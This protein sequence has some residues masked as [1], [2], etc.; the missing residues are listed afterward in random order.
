[1][2][3]IYYCDETFSARI[4]CYR[5]IRLAEKC[6]QIVDAKNLGPIP[7]SNH[8]AD[9]FGTEKVFDLLEITYLVDKIICLVLCARLLRF[10]IM[11]RR[12]GKT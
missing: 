11:Y 2:C 7:I 8:T 6:K 3:A 12:S 5:R 4:L 10:K 9:A 1:M